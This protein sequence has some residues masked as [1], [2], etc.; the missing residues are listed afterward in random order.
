MIHTY[1]ISPRQ[2]VVDAFTDAGIL[3]TRIIESTSTTQ[4]TTDFASNEILVSSITDPFEIADAICEKSASLYGVNSICVGLGDQTS[5]TASVVN[6]LLGAVREKYVPISTLF[7]LKNK[8]LL[9]RLLAVKLPQYSGY[10][11]VVNDIDEMREAFHRVRNGI[12]VKPLSGSG[13]RGV[14]RLQSEDDIVKNLTNFSFPALAEECFSGP[15]YSVEAITI[16]GK[17]QLLAVTEKILGGE[18]GVVE[19]GQIQPANIDDSTKDLLF[20]ATSNLLDAVGLNFG[21]SH[22]EIILE[23]DKP[24]I[25]ESHGRVGGDRIADLLRFTTGHNAFERLGAAIDKGVFLPIE[26]IASGSRIDYVDLSDYLGSDQE[27]KDKALSDPNVHLA[28]VLR[29]AGSR[30]RIWCSA[31]RHAFTISVFERKV[32]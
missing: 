5:L 11:K 27:W 23:G 30:G 3:V 6:E 12:V 25:V 26:P 16:D 24:K 32:K 1:V 9:R 21:L 20:E 18:S 29:P 19:I 28:E 13:S 2:V 14:V 17:H 31:D 10:F 22:T 7:L 8:L 4:D 15:E